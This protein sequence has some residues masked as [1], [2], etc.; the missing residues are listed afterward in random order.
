[1]STFTRRIFLQRASLGVAA[2]GGVLAWPRAA[3]AASQRMPRMAAT[4]NAPEP[5]TTS[6]AGATTTSDPVVAYVRN[7]AAGEISLFVG[8]R[9]VRLR[10]PDL[11]QRLIQAGA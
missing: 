9:E 10:D 2:V 11:A 6:K 5:A 8:T 1:M 3:G 7:P 4:P